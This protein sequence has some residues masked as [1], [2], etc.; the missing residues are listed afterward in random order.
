M[1]GIEDYRKWVEEAKPL[2]GASGGDLYEKRNN[3]VAEVL[4]QL[5][6][7]GSKAHTALFDTY[8]RL[9]SEAQKAVAAKDQKKVEAI[10][11]ELKTLKD[12]ANNAIR[13][14]QL[15]Q[16]KLDKIQKKLGD[17]TQK[18][19]ESLTKRA[20][21]RIKELGLTSASV[22]FIAADFSQVYDG[23]RKLVGGL[24]PNSDTSQLVS[25]YGIKL[26]ELVKST[27]ELIANNRILKIQ[28]EA[29]AETEAKAAAEQDRR[30]QETALKQKKQDL[31]TSLTGLEDVGVEVGAIA[32]FKARIPEVKT[33]DGATKLSGEI[34][35]KKTDH[36]NGQK[37]KIKGL[38]SELE[39]LAKQIE[40]KKKE[41][42]GNDNALKALDA[43]GKEA[44]Q[45]IKLAES[46]NPEALEGAHLL[47]KRI[48]RIVKSS[49]PDG[50]LGQVYAEI[51][52][53]GKTLEDKDLQ[54][55]CGPKTN[56][57]KDRLKKLTGDVDPFDLPAAEAEI[58]SIKF[59]AVSLVE[60]KDTRLA[61]QG[62]V[63]KW[64]DSIHGMVDELNAILKGR[65]TAVEKV[66]GSF[67]DLLTGKT[68]MANVLLKDIEAV[69]QQPGANQAAIDAKRVEVNGRM[70]SLMVA[71]KDPATDASTA[72]QQEY[73]DASKDAQSREDAK[74]AEQNAQERF[75]EN[76]EK[77]KKELEAV[78]EKVEA[79][80]GPK[81]ELDTLE[82]M[83]QTAKTM[84]KNGDRKGALERMAVARKRL[85]GLSKNPGGFAVNDKSELDRAAV[86]W[87]S[88]IDAVGEQLNTL[89]AQASE[90]AKSIGSNPDEVGKKIK[91]A[92]AAFD[93]QAFSSAAKLIDETLLLPQRKKL[94]EE[95]LVQVRRQ[96]SILQ[97]DPVID[98]VRTSPFKTKVSTAPIR[99]ALDGLELNAL[100]AVPAE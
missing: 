7:K 78:R 43:L 27:T 60:E 53:I 2:I 93:R 16:E 3:Q 84:E 95:V 14:H 45:L 69:Y 92:L 77:F 22:A 5:Q 19:S 49:A 11:S 35:K 59:L 81:A 36:E 13:D 26:A 87:N 97:N 85:A 62:G 96:R 83:S 28:S 29:Q 37:T 9:A 47:A 63:R 17:D 31:L 64:L 39:I 10:N 18:A 4:E 48:E 34:A 68:L 86:R 8:K 51:T 75:E 55:Y 56:Q 90:V 58:A 67:G 80:K 32:G 15:W 30:A 12:Q 54:K 42:K 52:E 44:G 21:A 66:F 98:M 82:K 79:K 46:N 71:A 99:Q 73:D 89:A 40:A 24:A 38:S 1:P 88:A 20:Q 74:T 100:R 61:W 91:S 41:L 94:R 33:L 72:L 65:D 6:S 23:L 57:L 25:T 50:G 76:R 70:R